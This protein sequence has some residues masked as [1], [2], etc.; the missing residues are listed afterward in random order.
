VQ[1]SYRIALLGD[2]VAHSL[3]PRLHGA[4]FA[5]AGIDGSY[6]AWRVAAGDL[7]EAVA[8][9]R[10]EGYAGANV[11]IPH[12]ETVAQHLDALTERAEA[13]G[14][15]NTII[16]QREDGAGGGVRLVGDNTDVAGFLAPLEEARPEAPTFASLLRGH[17]VVVFGAGGAA[18]AVAYAALT[19]LAPTRLTLA[20][21]TKR[22][23]EKLARALSAFDE[24]GA[25]DVV[26]LDRAGERV[27]KAALLVN[28]TPLGMHGA[29]E[30]ATP[31]PEASDLGTGHICYDLVYAP[32]QT[33]FL[34]DAVAC[35]AT[36]IGGLPM[37]VGQAAAAFEQWTGAD[38]PLG[39][40]WRP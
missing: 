25:L 4:A 10:S 30:D 34:K 32:A 12:K 7:G 5:A 14:A 11:T 2:P 22:R 23:A 28:A 33:R 36:P 40:D 20:A 16:A 31:W 3:S 27:E 1:P 17:E 37:L 38:W 15:V 21:R 26:S 6:E 39:L 13:V 29:H 8:M 24:S 9:L 35:G 19:A 18:R